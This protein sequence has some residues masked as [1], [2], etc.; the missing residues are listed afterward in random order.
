MYFYI[1]KEKLPMYQTRINLRVS[2]CMCGVGGGEACVRGVWVC[3]GVG[4]G[5]EIY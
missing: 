4:V 1:L 2:L 3:G 5:W